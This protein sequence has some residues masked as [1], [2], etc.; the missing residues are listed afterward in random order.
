MLSAEVLPDGSRIRWVELAGV[1]PTLVF[2]HGLGASSPPYYGSV[3]ARLEFAGRRRLLV[4]L[5]G[6]GI[7][8]RPDGLGYT[9]E[10]HAD[11][12]A[13]ALGAAGVETADLVAHS[14]GGAVAITLAARHPELVARLVLVDSNLDPLDPSAPAGSSRIASY[15]EAEFVEHGWA[16]TLDRVGPH[17]AATMRLSGPVALHRTAV[18][19]ARGTRPT[20]RENLLALTVPRTFLYPEGDGPGAEDALEAGGVELVAVP[21]AGHNIML[22]APDAFTDAVVEATAPGRQ[23]LATPA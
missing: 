16:E 2:V 8:D 18:G 13:T 10:D 6:F 1:E 22:D 3:A 5:L 4:D 7:S 9:L 11:T 19:L 12:L 23:Q 17:W 14:M 15:S 21:G 20:M